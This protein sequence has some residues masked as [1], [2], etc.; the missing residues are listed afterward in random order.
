LASRTLRDRQSVGLQIRAA[1][2]DKG[3]FYIE[4]HG[5]PEKLVQ[6]VFAEAAAFFSLP[7]ERKAEIDKAKSKANRG[8]EP[9]QG[10][11]L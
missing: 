4:N 7:A 8:Y 6:S 5:V 1:C 11:T 10:Q 9:L 2:L 3:F